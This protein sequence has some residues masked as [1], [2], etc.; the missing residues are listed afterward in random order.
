[1]SPGVYLA[2]PIDQGRADWG[3]DIALGW[4]QE[5]TGAWVYDPLGA[6]KVGRAPMSPALRSINM[7]ALEQCSVLLAFLPAG[8]P[9]V[10][11]PMEIESAVSMGKQVVVI[12]KAPSWSMQYNRPNL[13]VVPEW[14]E[15]AQDAVIEAILRAQISD[16]GWNVAKAIE[17]YTTR[18]APGGWVQGRLWALPEAQEGISEALA[19]WD[20]TPMPTVVSEGAEAPRRGYAD[21]AGLD[22]VVSEARTIAPGEFVDIPCGVSVELPG[23]SFGMITGRSST[24]RKRGLMV[25]QGIIDAGYRGPLFAG[26]WNLGD[27]DVKVEAGERI[28]QL[29]VLHNG[30]RLV[31]V[32]QVESLGE[33]SRGHNGFGSTGT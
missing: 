4:L 28:A 19:G 33:G 18:M 16:S 7:H 22:L 21:D 2:R 5:E 13:R 14:N 3:P 32:E 31:E 30:T 6:F 20:P 26:V 12:S 11:V 8:V 10:G 29:L 15:A 17:P 23:W 1:M 25:N 9:T 27:V 24:L